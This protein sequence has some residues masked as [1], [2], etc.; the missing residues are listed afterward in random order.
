MNTNVRTAGYI[1]FVILMASM[2]ALDA[3]SIDAMLPALRHIGEE[4]SLA[5]SN[6]RQYVVTTLFVG[7][8]V[9]VLVYGFVADQFGR[10]KP[11]IAGFL[12]FI[13]GSFLCLTANSFTM[14]LT[15]RFFQGLG[16]AGPYVLSIA[17]VRDQ[18][19]GDKMART[20]SLIMMVFIGVPM[21]APFVGQGILMLSGWR[22]IF[23][24]LLLFGLVTM[25]WFWLRQVETLSPELKKPLSLSSI[26]DSFVETLSS[27]QTLRYILG[28]G[29]VFGAFMAYLST[30]QQIFQEMFQLGNYFPLV[31]AAL[32]SL[33]G[34]GSY[35]NARLVDSVGSARLVHY[36]LIAIVSGSL[37]HLITG[38]TISVENRLWLY[39]AYVIVVMSAF[40][41]L[42]GNMTSLALEPL[43]HIAGT[44]SSLVS[45]IST[46]LAIVFGSFI[47]SRLEHTVTPVV[48]G[49]GTL[50]LVSIFLNYPQ[51]KINS[52]KL[53]S[54]DRVC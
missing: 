24:A 16:A 40:A 30:G 48:I 19:E 6:Q 2:A 1:E 12:L 54:L 35:L 44:A 33:F 36:A 53:V 21:I 25:I 32:A 51:L 17:I 23:T 38:M 31:F 8:S 50:C 14:L 46:A 3:F 13:L 5:D 4:F 43:G 42:F 22:S 15:G 9:G 10:R 7:F 18:Y 11:A 20:L 27:G 49:F 45:S 29:A 26:A 28:L 41:F 47:G 39:I 37:L 34:I 52:G